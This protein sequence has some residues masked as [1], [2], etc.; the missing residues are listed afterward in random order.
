MRHKHHSH[1]LA[2]VFIAVSSLE[3]LLLTFL[4]FVLE[5]FT[6]V[7][8]VIVLMERKKWQNAALFDLPRHSYAAATARGKLVPACVCNMSN[9]F[10]FRLYFVCL[11]ERILIL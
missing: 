9:C 4:E 6:T 10:N 2:C 3:V 5:A 8:N 7:N 1:V 11:R